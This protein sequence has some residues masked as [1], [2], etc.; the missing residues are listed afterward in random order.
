M[1]W[2]RL[3]LNWETKNMI[4]FTAQT[5]AYLPVHCTYCSKSPRCWCAACATDAFY[6]FISGLFWG[7][8]GRADGRCQLLPAG[9]CPAQPCYSAVHLRQK[10]LILRSRLESVRPL[11]R[12]SGMLGIFF[13]IFWQSSKEPFSVT[14]IQENALKCA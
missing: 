13:N 6:S 5:P 1:L 14:Q 10:R 9:A 12:S 4:A 3:P 8:S 2:R 11:P 7:G